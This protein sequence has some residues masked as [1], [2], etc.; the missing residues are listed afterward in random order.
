[1]SNYPI[2]VELEID[3]TWVDVSDRARRF[4]P[5]IRRGRSD[6]ASQVQ[7]TTATVVLENTDG[8]L[9][10]RNPES[11]WYPHIR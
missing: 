8:E 6:E 5:V 7:P 9:S 1:M 2:L 3:G 11:A 4:P 10:P